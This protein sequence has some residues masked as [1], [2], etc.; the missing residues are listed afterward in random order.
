MMKIVV[1]VTAVLNWNF[2][3]PSAMPDNMMKKSPTQKRRSA[4]FRS[5]YMPSTARLMLPSGPRI[6]RAGPKIIHQLEMHK[7]KILKPIDTET[8]V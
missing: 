6:A 8:R 2:S 7:V 4:H 1:I 3:Q 5:A